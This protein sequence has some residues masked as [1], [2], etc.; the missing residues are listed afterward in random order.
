M[1]FR[2]TPKQARNISLAVVGCLFLLVGVML[3]IGALSGQPKA[4]EGYITEAQ[5]AQVQ[6]G[7]TSDQ[8]A[9]IFGRNPDDAEAD[10]GYTPAFW[11]NPDGS[12]A[13]VLFGPNGLA[14]DKRA[15]KLP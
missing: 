11:T 2:L 1:G 3:A 13:W 5:L 6:F 14:N 7:M 9:T 10:G 4:P 8:V 12:Y 15:F